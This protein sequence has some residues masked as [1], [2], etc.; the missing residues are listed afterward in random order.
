MLSFDE[1]AKLA[2]FCKKMTSSSDKVIS[3]YAINDKGRLLEY[4]RNSNF[5]QSDLFDSMD[6]S[7]KEMFFM[8]F[9][10]RQRMR[11]EFNEEFGRV[12][13]TCAE[14]EKSTMLSFPIDDRILVIVLVTTDVDPKMIKDTF[15]EFLNE[16]TYMK[17]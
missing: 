6:K 5:E 2:S 9:A 10:L 8:E 15:F 11:S 4:A 13:Y 12:V 3:V 7:K 17:T 14:R 1:N 16:Y